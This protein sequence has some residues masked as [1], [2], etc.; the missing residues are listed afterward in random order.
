MKLFWWSFTKNNEE[1]F[2]F[3]KRINFDDYMLIDWI[4]KLFSN[5][6]YRRFFNDNN[7]MI[8]ETKENMLSLQKM[9]SLRERYISNKDEFERIKIHNQIL[10]HFH[11]MKT[12]SFSLDEKNLLQDFLNNLNSQIKKNKK[13]EC[14]KL[15]EKTKYEKYLV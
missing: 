14:N 7:I 6:N 15:L 8:N 13:I 9:I 1:L 5:F 3:V 11:Y 4:W 12:L 2:D 10:E